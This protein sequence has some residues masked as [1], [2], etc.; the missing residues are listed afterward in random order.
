VKSLWDELDDLNE[1]PLCT[2]SSADKLH[3]R[4][5]DQKLLQ[6][7]MGLNDDYKA[8]RGNIL[9]MNPLPT[10]GQVYSM[11]IQEEKQRE[12]RSIGQIFGDSASLAIE[13]HKPNNAYKGRTER[14]EGRLENASSKFERAEI[15]KKSNLFCNYYKKTGHSIDKCCRLHGFPTNF[16]FKNPRRTAALVHAGDQENGLA[17][18]EHSSFGSQSNVTVPGLTQEQSS[19]LITLLQNVQATKSGNN[20]SYQGSDYSAPSTGFTSLAGIDTTDHTQNLCLLSSVADWKNIWIVD[21]GATDHMCHNR[22]LFTDLTSLFKPVVVT[23]PDG[24]SIPVTQSGT[25]VFSNTLSLHGVLYIPSFKYNLLSVSKLCNRDGYFIVFTPKCCLMQAPSVKRP[26]VLGEYFGGLYLLQS[27]HEANKI[28]ADASCCSKNIFPRNQI[29]AYTANSPSDDV[30]LWHARLGHLP[31][32]K[33]L[34]LGLFPTQCSA[35]V[36]R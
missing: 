34:S 35:D 22:D 5:Q 32:S 10:I 25:I 8:V 23:L 20:T 4:E 18:Q 15:A 30:T 26:Q 17:V 6:F 11:L 36:I 28:G 2:C 3:K 24:K 33:L 31:F 14:I 16:K 27:R 21:T 12:I 9:M 19:Q 7:L 13:V 29:N 1:I